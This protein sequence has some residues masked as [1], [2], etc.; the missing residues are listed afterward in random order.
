[1]K[2]SKAQLKR[3]IREEYSKIKK[4]SRLNEAKSF[5]WYESKMPDFQ[6]TSLKGMDRFGDH[7]TLFG[8]IR[9]HEKDDPGVIDM[10]ID[11][12][13]EVQ[14]LYQDAYGAEEDRLYEEEGLF[15]N[16]PEYKE[17]TR[18][19]LSDHRNDWMKK[20]PTSGA[21]EVIPERVWGML[22]DYIIEDFMSPDDFLKNIYSARR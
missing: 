16:E 12:T 5:P 8:N 2:I 14:D 19:W 4:Q 6:I 11:W 22:F 21:S 18:N 10:I 20:Y 9:D 1:M 17:A 3:I 7:S 15:G 13:H